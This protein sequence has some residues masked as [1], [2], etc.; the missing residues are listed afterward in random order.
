MIIILD[1]N[2]L[3]KKLTL[4]DI[5]IR[6]LTEYY[7]KL[8][9]KLIIPEIVLR[10]TINQVKEKISAMAKAN[11]D[12]YTKLIK[13]T[14]LY[15]GTAFQDKDII[16]NTKEYSDYINSLVLEHNITIYPIPTLS[17]E[18]IIERD[19]NRR[20]PFDTSGKGY[21]DT[22]I[23]ESILGIIKSHDDTIAFITSNTKDFYDEEKTSL[24]PDLIKD[25][26]DC[27][28]KKETIVLYNNLFD[29]IKN[30]LIPC[31]PKPTRTFAK[32]IH[33]TDFDFDDELCIKLSNYLTGE[34]IN[35]NLINKPPEIDSIHFSLVHN[36]S[37]IEVEEENELSE[38]ERILKISCR[39]NCEF[40]TYIYKPDLS[41]IP[42]KDIPFI[43]NHDWN[44]RYVAASFNEDINVDFFIT[45]NIK[46]I[47]ITNIERLEFY[48]VYE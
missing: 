13:E 35:P 36:V 25:L 5:S 12:R 40:D 41:I 48:S 10:E 44:D 19:L 29:F 4:K 47:A 9:H 15:V 43:W 45:V 42:E 23:W 30:E 28:K 21:R 46:D 14:G 7:Q 24:H 37:N 6:I 11:N 34:E 20:K 31:L 3:S 39:L 26:Y 8:N 22:L 1:T 2:V 38:N 18:Q 32:L 16:D 17:H 33:T 27:G